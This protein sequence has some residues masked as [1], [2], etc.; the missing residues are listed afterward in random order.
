MDSSALTKVVKE[1]SYEL[2]TP[3]MLP[4]PEDWKGGE[5][6]VD[7]LGKSCGEFVRK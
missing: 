3:T 1:S 4:P 6:A 7:E 5:L 2:F